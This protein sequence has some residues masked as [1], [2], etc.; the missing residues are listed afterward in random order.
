MANSFVEGAADACTA[1]GL[2]PLLSIGALTVFRRL[3]KPSSKSTN[4]SS[5]SSSSAT[6]SGPYEPPPLDPSCA[7]RTW[8]WMDLASLLPVLLLQPRKGHATLDM[9]AAPGGKSTLVAQHIFS[10]SASS[11]PPPLV[12]AP[13]SSAAG[14]GQEGTGPGSAGSSGGAGDAVAAAGYAAGASPLPLGPGKLS[15]NEPDRGRLQRLNRVLEEYLPTTARMN[16][17]VGIGTEHVVRPRD[18]ARVP[19]DW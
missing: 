6:S 10:H 19:S 5:S 7:L 2:S 14:T 4:S 1:S 8:Y 18:T 3:A 12:A 11:L 13:S 17:E 15:C 16:V 9:C